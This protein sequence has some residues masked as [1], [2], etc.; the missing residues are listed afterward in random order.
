MDFK[1]AV[2]L[3]SYMKHLQKKTELESSVRY[4]SK[5]DHDISSRYKR[6]H[7]VKLSPNRKNKEFIKKVT[8]KGFRATK[9]TNK[10]FRFVNR[11]P[12]RYQV[13]YY[14]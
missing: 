13:K 8:G 14:S 9:R 2:L 5:I 7:Q 1:N 11:R 3:L 10:T 4:V 12:C 6:T